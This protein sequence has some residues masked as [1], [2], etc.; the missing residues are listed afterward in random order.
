M[1]LASLRRTCPLLLAG[2]SALPP[3][4]G[5]ADRPDPAAASAT[6]VVTATRTE[7]DAADTPATVDVAGREEL[8]RLLA[9]RPNDLTRFMPGVDVG[10]RPGRQGST[11]FNIRG[12][13]ENRV[14]I[15]V[16][17]VNLP[18][19]PEAGRNFSRDLV[20]L[21]SVRRVEIL[22]GPASALYGSDALG[23]VVSYTTVD[24]RDLIP[25]RDGRFGSLKLGCASADHSRSATVTAAGRAGAWDGLLL[26]TLRRGAQFDPA[27]GQP[28]PMTI[29]GSNLLGKVGFAPSDR[30]RFSFGVQHLERSTGV[31]LLS[32]LGPIPH[33]PI[34][35]LASQGDDLARRSQFTL[36][37]RFD[38]PSAW[39]QHA[40]WRAY[41]QSA[42]TRERTLELRD[43][44]TGPVSRWSDS[45]FIQSILG[46]RSQAHR[47]FQ[48]GTTAHRLLVGLDL[49]RAETSRPYD[50]TQTDLATG[51]ATRT[52]AG[53]TYPSKVCPDSTT[54]AMGAF[55]QD[56]LLSGS[57]QVMAIP[58]LRLDGFALQPHPD[59]DFRR[60]D[61][62]GA[63]VRAIANLALSPRLALLDGLAPGWVGYAAYGQGFR[64]PPYDNANMAFANRAGGFSYQ[65]M[66]NPGLGPERSYGLEAGLRGEGRDGSASLALFYNRYRDFIERS[67]LGTDPSGVYLFQYRN[68]KRV[69]ILGAEARA[70]RTLAPGLQAQ[71]SAAWAQGDNLSSGQPLDSVAPFKAVAALQ[72]RAPGEAWGADLVWTGVAR[73]TRVPPPDALQTGSFEAPV[74]FRA[75]GY[76]VLDA[77]AFAS[78]APGLKITF[79]VFNLLDQTCW[80]WEDVRGF[81]AGDPAVARTSQPG[82]NFAL[83]VSK[84]WMG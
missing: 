51:A 17:G 63:P 33:T 42:A 66:P 15:L 72:Y 74:P 53:S 11:S 12:I 19:G 31:D 75:P 29:R 25:G 10:S 27:V 62:Q 44:G 45:R 81:G 38:D 46:V 24:A 14:L 1:V 32:D 59:A 30:H 7:R 9:D 48:T 54:W 50:R 64:N 35:V 70:A 6:V 68:Y 49:S 83:T 3:A 60:S 56:E 78:P 40:Q 57:G 79:G 37:H 84:A 76:G 21:D 73:K 80:H 82:R 61:V 22:R 39:F 16:D 2:A 47:R 69:R 5:A 65:V 13:D 36:E 23:G 26:G 71:F 28:N 4:A 18:D 52:V 77:L 20:D 43:P 34:Q 67:N 58:G 8:D 41:F 55:V